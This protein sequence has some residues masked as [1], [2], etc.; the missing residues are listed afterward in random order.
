MFYKDEEIKKERKN[1]SSLKND[2]SVYKQEEGEKEKF[3]KEEIKNLEKMIVKEKEIKKD[4][5]RI[6]ESDKETNDIE[7]DRSIIPI[8]S[9]NKHFPKNKYK[10]LESPGTERL[11]PNKIPK[12][13]NFDTYK[14]KNKK[15]YSYHSPINK[16][17]KRVRKVVRSLEKINPVIDKRENNKGDF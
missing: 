9:R 17:F 4:L 3:L 11:S 14:T 7:K 2:F 10:L 12:K 15:K 1:S 5:K 16:S 8:P 13:L 6:L